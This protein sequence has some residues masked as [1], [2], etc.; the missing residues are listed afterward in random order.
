[1]C[2]RGLRQAKQRRITLNFARLP[3]DTLGMG[4]H[5]SGRRAHARGAMLGRRS[6]V[7]VCGMAVMACALSACD[8]PSAGEPV[9]GRAS[10]Q[11]G[12]VRVG[13]QAWDLPSRV[14]ES[15]APVDQVLEGTL[16]GND[17]AIE[18]VPFAVYGELLAALAEGRVD[19]ARL[20][21]G[22]YLTALQRERG[23]TLLAIERP[24]RGRPRQ[25]M[26]VT[27]AQGSIG[28]LADLRGKSFAFG[29]EHAAIGRHLA[30]AALLAAGLH[31]SDL[32]RTA[33]LRRGD[34]IAAAVRLGEFDAGVIEAD[35]FRRANAD[36]SL[37]VLAPVIDA[38]RPWVARAGLDA[39]IA[40]ALSTALLALDDA[41]C[42]QVL[43]ASGLERARDDTY[44]SVRTAMTAAALFTAGGSLQVSAAPARSRR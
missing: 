34:K 4:M 6:G 31:A 40:A 27:S 29:D 18:I 35:V 10:E 11:S 37:R 21:S 13:V 19:V 17:L 16:R 39:E 24:G 43:D 44:A 26:I 23:L 8:A 41:R 20:D 9:A 12:V 28:T 36:G 1:M 33:Y 25:G 5:V 22:S 30:Q 15:F 38:P 3:D 7:T 32:G 14:E 2:E 42:L